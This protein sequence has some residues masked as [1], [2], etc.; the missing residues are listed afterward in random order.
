MTANPF[1]GGRE[2][3][4]AAATSFSSAAISF[5]ATAVP[6]YWRMSPALRAA[7]LFQNLKTC[8]G[9]SYVIGKLL[10]TL[11]NLLDMDPLPP[12]VDKLVHKVTV[13]FII[14]TI[15]MRWLCFMGGKN[16]GRILVIMMKSM[17]THALGLRNVSNHTFHQPPQDIRRTVPRGMALIYHVIKC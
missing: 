4:L 6:L 5:L 11:F 10:P 3:F 2:S 12:C 13:F 16:Y 15:W 8:R 14:P 1:L 9:N 7:F 17:N